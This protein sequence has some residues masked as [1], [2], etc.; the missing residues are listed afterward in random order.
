MDTSLPSPTDI[1]DPASAVP[2][3][4]PT[5]RVSARTSAMLFA[6]ATT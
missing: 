4:G 1:V 5:Y 6:V 3:N 2:V